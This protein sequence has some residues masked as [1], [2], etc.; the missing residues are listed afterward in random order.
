VKKITS[1][2]NI[3]INNYGK[4]QLQKIDEM[5]NRKES[6]AF[7]TTLSGLNYLRRIKCWQKLGYEVILYF[8]KLPNEEM[9]ID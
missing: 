7:E 4:L 3:I 9:A 8:L 5:V 1:S 2:N 6:F